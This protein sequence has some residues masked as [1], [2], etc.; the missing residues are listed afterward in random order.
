M[1]FLSPWDNSE[2]VKRAWCLLELF[3]SCRITAI[4]SKTDIELFQE[5]LGANFCTI[6]RSIYQIDVYRAESY[7][8]K[9]KENIFEVIK[10]NGGF[11]S[12]NCKFISL[13]RSWVLSESKRHD[14]PLELYDQGNINSFKE[15]MES[16]KVAFDFMSSNF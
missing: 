15:A 11:E 14:I 1:C 6:S 4:F 5:K 2:Y 16:F 7:K 10:K 12:F 13:I 8:E 9:D 3:Y